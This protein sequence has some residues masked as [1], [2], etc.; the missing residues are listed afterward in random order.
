MKKIGTILCMLLLAAVGNNVTAQ[1]SYVQA[2]DIPVSISGSPIKNPWVGGFNAPMFS[3]IDLDG[4][5]VK[6]LF[7]FDKE[8]NR[9][10]TYINNGTPN[11]VDYVYAPEYEK[12]FP[13]ILADWVMLVDFDCD[14]REDI[15]A[16]AVIAGG[17]TVFK[18]NYTPQTGLQFDL[19]HDLVDSKYGTVSANLYVSRVNI[20]ALADVDYDGDLDV[21]TFP[22]AGNFVE[23]HKNMG[24]ELFNR[25]DTLV[26]EIMPNCYGSFGLSGFSNTAILNVSC[27]LA[28]PDGITPPAAIKELN[29]LHSGSCMMAIDIDGDVDYDLLNGDIL[30]NNL[31]LI[32]N[33]GTS[34]A[35]VMTAQDSTFP[36]YD[37]PVNMV[38][39]P[40]PYYFDANN[41]GN[42]DLIVAPCISGPA[43]NYNNILYYNNTTNNQ[44]NIFNYQ[45]NRFLSNEMIEVG[46]GANVTF[47]DIDSDGLKDLI[48]G[49]YGYFSVILPFESG[50]SY[51]KNTGTASNP[52]FELQT[53]DFG[54]FF[55]LPMNTGLDPAFGDLDSD[56]DLDL[57]LGH[58]DGELICYRNTAGQGNP[59]VYALAQPQLL[60]N[61]NAPI[62][63]GQ[64]SAPQIIDV[65]KDG[66]LDLIIGERSGNINYYENTGTATVPVFTLITTNF[67]GVDV[68]TTFTLYGYSNPCMYDSAGTYQLLVGSAIGYIYQYNNIDNN[69]S[70][71]FNLVDSMFYDI[72]EPDQVT[73]DVADL[74]NDGIMEIVTGN[75]AGGLSLYKFDATIGLPVVPEAPKTFNIYPNPA[76]DQ[77]FVKFETPFYVERDITLIDMLG[78][79][80]DHKLSGSNVVLFETADLSSGMYHCRVIEGSNVTTLKFMV[81]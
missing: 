60:D 50:L 25:C 5:G 12:I 17:M 77:L 73:V 38:T 10:T 36:S 47:V 2:N 72:H 62:D 3:A 49:N 53:M 51:Y 11:T 24:Q 79:V 67:G 23:F 81:K 40:A 22:V 58:T 37:V 63:V 8:G 66:K 30:G 4:N 20:P 18:N 9:V 16:Y 76:S 42:K 71:N 56:G 31:L 69:L 78:R 6:D 14:G 32:E 54:N 44:T 52:S 75:Y 41:D 34:A 19:V 74:D 15:F 13:S 43:E 68:N 29:S 55:S 61:N 65:N 80:V 46:A 33:G 28:I 64:F 27:R 21:L 26:Y 70:G 45:V 39:F 59:P 48:V 1:G 35:P 57:L 7:V